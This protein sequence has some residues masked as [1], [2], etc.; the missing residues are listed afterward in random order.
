MK[1]NHY[2]LLECCRIPPQ[3]FWK[4]NSRPKV[5]IAIGIISKH[6]RWPEDKGRIVLACDS[7]MTYSS[8]PKD[9]D[10]R[11]INIIEFA[12]AKVLTVQSGNAREATLAIKTIQ[13]KARGVKIEDLQTVK[14]VF[15]ESMREVRKSLLEGWNF[16]EERAKTYLQL[17]ADCQFLVAFYFSGEP[18]LLHIDNYFCT[19]CPSENGDYAAIGIG[20]DLAQF[21]LKEYKEADANFEHVDLIAPAVIKKVKDNVKDCAGLTWV[22]IAEHVPDGIAAGDF[23]E[24]KKGDII[25][26]DKKCTAFICRRQLTDAITNELKQR[27]NKIKAET[28]KQLLNTLVSLCKN[29]GALVYTES[30][31]PEGDG[32]FRMS[33]YWKN[34]KDRDRAMK[35]LMGRVE[36]KTAK[37]AS[38]KITPAV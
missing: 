5:T 36:S 15:E 37:K 18:Y 32:G 31:D 26:A 25:P 8:G 33:G 21:L 24:Y 27:E 11:K 28:S 7:Q 16:T 35:K 38:P 34:S 10:A 13:G 19:L 6:K 29:I 4:P 22:G 3:R 17:E 2:N 30:D 20:S 14:N 1:N 23:L 12:N 9:L